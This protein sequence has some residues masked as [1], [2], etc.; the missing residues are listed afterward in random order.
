MSVGDDYEKIRQGILSGDVKAV[1]EVFDDDGDGHI[2]R[3][4]LLVSH[5]WT[6]ITLVMMGLVSLSGYL[7][8]HQDLVRGHQMA[9]MGML[10]TF[11]IGFF[12]GTLFF[13]PRSDG[14]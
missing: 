1:V 8:K 2:S 5:R 11:V 9:V 10:I 14:N 3:H 4:E 12:L 7:T 6:F 13:T